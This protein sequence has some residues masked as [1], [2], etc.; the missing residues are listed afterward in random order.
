MSAL[1]EELW[2]R[3]L[4]I[5]VQRRGV[6]YK[7]L[8]CLSISSRRLHRLCDEDF[9]WSHLL[10]S[11]FPPFFS[12][13]S[14][15]I[16][17]AHSSSCKYL[18]KLRYERDR[19][20]KIAA[21]RRAVLRKESQVLERFMRL[22]DMETRLAEETNKMRATLAELSNLS[23]VRQA[24]VALNV[25]QPEII[26]GRQKQIVEQCV[27]PVESRFHVLHMELKLC[28]QQI[29]GLEKAH[30]D[31][32]R[33][34]ALVEEELQSMRYHPLRDQKPINSGEVEFNIKRKKLKKCE[35]R[36]P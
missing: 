30:I 15:S 17:S 19:D 22:R 9:L 4:E 3:I 33:R 31:E 8:C 35:G 12:P 36:E 10:S 25:W 14:S 11:D 32:K 27:V 23:N 20:K 16:T 18:Y 28:K 34:L 29:L 7:D 21:H 24:S 5:G 2:R 1:P 13:S 26:R 6:S